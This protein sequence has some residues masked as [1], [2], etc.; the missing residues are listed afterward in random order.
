MKFGEKT[1]KILKNFVSI[2]ESVIFRQGKVLSTI[3]S[4]GT[5]YAIANIEETIP[6]DFAIY[7]LNRFLMCIK[8]FDE[9]D[10]EFEEKRAKIRSKN[11]VI[12]YTYA[13]EEMVLDDQK[14]KVIYK[15]I[16]LPSNDVQFSLSYGVYNDCLKAMSV[17]GTDDLMIVGDGVSLELRTLD[18]KS[19]TSDVY[20]V[21][22]GET[23]KEFKVTLKNESLKLL[24]NDYNVSI[25]FNGVC[26]FNSPQIDYFLL[27]KVD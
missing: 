7:D 3:S 24:E 13:A 19:P 16:L 18:A 9:Y 6:L 27:S 1:I 12:N 17:L 11:S 8:M 10:L 4:T 22:I 26:H 2:N 21:K 5:I 14:R 23:S 15:N 25:C 20:S